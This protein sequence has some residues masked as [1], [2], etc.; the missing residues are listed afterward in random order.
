M[1]IS[2]RHFLSSSSAFVVLSATA[3]SKLDNDNVLST[4]SVQEVTMAAP[5][6]IR[7]EIRD[8]SIQRGSIYGPF[9]SD[10]AQLQRWTLKKHPKT[11]LLGYARIIGPSGTYWRFG[12]T[13][14]TDYYNRAEGD[15]ASNWTILGG[16]TT[17]SAVYRKS[18]PCDQ[19]VTFT[20]ADGQ[21]NLANFK[22]YVYLKL[23]RNLL[24][25]EYTII[26]GNAIGL[27]EIS[28]TFD[29]KVTRCCSIRATQL[30][31]RAG[32]I[33][34]YA[35][36]AEWV[37]GLGANGAI[38][39]AG[40][41][42]LAS[43]NIIDADGTVVYNGAGKLTARVA[44]TDTET[45][46]GTNLS[47]PNVGTKKTL[48]AI[49]K[50]NP[51]S[52][53]CPAHGF[54]TNDKVYFHCIG[55]M[56]QLE[57]TASNNFTITV[58]DADNFTIGVDTRSFGTYAPGFYKD[59][60]DSSV[61]KIDVANRA[62]TFVL[63]MDYGSANWTPSA[64]GFYRVQI[65]GL[66]VSDPFEVGEAVWYKMAHTAC[67]G[68]YHQTNGIALDG[69]FGF[70]RPACHRDGVGGCNV[71]WSNLPAIWTSEAGNS[72]VSAIGIA[73]PVPPADG[74]Y[75][76]YITATRA[77]G[78]YGAWRDAGDWD[79]Y[80]Q[81]HAQSV[82]HLIDVCYEKIKMAHLGAEVTNF[83][84]PKSSQTLDP[85][86]Y[87]GTDSLPDALHQAIYWADFY[88][89]LQNRNS[90][91]TLSYGSVGSAMMFGGWGG[92]GGDPSEPSYLNSYDGSDPANRGP[93]T[94]MAP[95]HLS[96]YW[97]AGIF[98]K[99][100][101]QF[102]QLGLTKLQ[103][104]YQDAAVLAW[105][106]AEPLYAGTGGRG[107]LTNQRAYYNGVLNLQANRGDSDATF[108]AA[109]VQIDHWIYHNAGARSFA[110]A[111][112]FRLT[113]N[114]AY[115][116][117]IEAHGLGTLNGGPDLWEY[118]FSNGSLPMWRNYYVNHWTQA[119]TFTAAKLAYQDGVSY[120]NSSCHPCDMVGAIQ[121]M[122]MSAISAALNA[123]Q[124][125][126]QAYSNAGSS[127][128]SAA[129]QQNF[130]QIIQNAESY[131]M[132]A[133]QTGICCM[134]GLGAR[135]TNMI[136][137][138]DKEAMGLV[139]PP[140]GY[141]PYM[142]N[143]NQRGGAGPF[144]FANGPNADA[145]LNFCS[146]TPTGK[147]EL[148]FGSKRIVDPPADAWPTAEAFWE[149]TYNIFCEEFTT[150]QTIIPRQYAAMWLHAWDGN[151]TQG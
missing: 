33:G 10:V 132:G 88:R 122:I 120:A 115:R 109:L 140:K 30:G 17:I 2:R 7:L 128:Y 105:N 19:G 100:A 71:F 49:T 52:V 144:N 118:L 66:G 35:Y 68:Y 91:D 95:D 25:G 73:N 83:N 90:S 12:D 24:Q 137:H 94:I 114:T 69:R 133:N 8:P 59:G 78:I 116:A 38:D 148:S 72:S 1:G 146:N 15:T 50:A 77:A 63:G 42:G 23:S 151:K 143:R 16:T 64:P 32:D 92:V 134:T 106:W 67:M 139:V 37:P 101:Y 76:P 47:Y 124:T 34:K 142:W 21:C 26:P 107:T 58:V 11:G 36:L 29:D 98:A 125:L 13:R 149:N 75:P 31:H 138:R 147:F 39:F 112:L 6:I 89:R 55:G 111:C 65:P 14:S 103:S 85:V 56:T 104:T 51:G 70:S 135:N 28:F 57:G 60:Y 121:G 5:D 74:A 102:Q 4:V 81:S 22:H 79:S 86:L 108:N 18:Q 46:F 27:G 150:Q 40:A 97:A 3:C 43:F 41:Y 130:M 99:L 110:A 93:T 9:G 129:A 113:G 136:L 141:V 127:Q 62:A 96:N 145:P 61:Y 84:F 87:A 117:I 48:Q 82:Y 131:L 20:A 45:G 123:G 44:P 119:S 53:H 54:S 126:A 80:L